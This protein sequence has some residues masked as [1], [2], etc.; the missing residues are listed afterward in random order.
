MS[1]DLKKLLMNVSSEKERK[2]LKEAYEAGKKAAKKPV[3][4]ST[5]VTTPPQK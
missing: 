5:F 2:A 1:E 4:N 3:L